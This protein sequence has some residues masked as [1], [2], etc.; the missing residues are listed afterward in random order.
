MA[1]PMA[2]CVGCFAATH[3]AGRGVGL[4]KEDK[5]VQVWCEQSERED[6][7]RNRPDS[8]AQNVEECGL[9]RILANVD[10]FLP[11][12]VA[13]IAAGTTAAED[14]LLGERSRWR[15]ALP[16]SVVWEVR[17]V[18]GLAGAHSGKKYNGRRH[19]SGGRRYEPSRPVTAQGQMAAI[20]AAGS[21]GN[22]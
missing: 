3:A 12:P 2:V 20:T 13:R 18:S 6:P 19:G 22:Y 5:T 16:Q 4:Q 11:I 17:C 14:E 1:G 15:G 9:R 8:T 7:S 10:Q 21:G